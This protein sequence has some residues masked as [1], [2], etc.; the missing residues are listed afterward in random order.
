MCNSRLPGSR[1]AAPCQL[2]N[3]QYQGAL[4]HFRESLCQIK[5]SFL[6]SDMRVL[7]QSLLTQLSC[8]TAK[9]RVI[10]D[11]LHCRV[12]LSGEGPLHPGQPAD[13]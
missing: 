10:N 8:N 12:S 5:G 7:G 4:E 1:V 9:D 11:L 6:L 3:Y 13:G 2:C